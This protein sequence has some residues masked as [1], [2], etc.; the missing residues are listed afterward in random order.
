MDIREER[1]DF[2][3][4][5]LRQ[6]SAQPGGKVGFCL[7]LACCLLLNMVFGMF[8][9]LLKLEVLRGIAQCDRSVDVRDLN[10]SE[11]GEKEKNKSID[12]FKNR[13]AERAR[14]RIFK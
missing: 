4:C 1:C 13:R 10:V 7:L 12:A 11:H 3:W 14:R 8:F 6:K 9:R 5:V 2:S